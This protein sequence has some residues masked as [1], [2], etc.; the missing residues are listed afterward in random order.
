MI[1]FAE[2]S[3]VQS[4]YTNNTINKMIIPL[5]LDTMADCQ[6]YR[7]LSQKHQDLDTKFA[8]AVGKKVC[9][10]GDFVKIQVDSGHIIYFIIIRAIDKFQPYIFDIIKCLDRVLTNIEK[11]H[12]TGETIFPMPT[13]DELKISD[14]IFIPVICNKLFESK[15]PIFILSNGDHES[16]IESISDEC[17]YYKRDSWKSDWMLSLDDLILIAVIKSVIIMCHDFKINKHNL[18][19]CY[20]H[21]HQNGLF[22]KIE[23]YT[24]DYGP[25]FRMFLP[26][27]NS[28]IN[29]GFILNTFHYSNSEPKKFSCSLGPNTDLLFFM[30]YSNIHKNR[31][32]INKIANDIKIDHIKSY[33][34]KRDQ[35]DQPQKQSNTQM[36]L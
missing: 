12:P 32:K 8:D 23:W 4:L 35:P 22:P 28:L 20:H 16:Y 3:Q 15:L 2:Y 19:R 14:C 7:S 17:I 13:S 18:V 6:L 21:C 29:H 24:T 10:V 27:S 30:A 1:T 11:D 33:Q 5:S 31:E 36:V 34:Q 9:K 26:K 25:F